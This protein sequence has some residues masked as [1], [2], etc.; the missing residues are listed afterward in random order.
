MSDS[1]DQTRIEM[2]QNAVERLEKRVHNLEVRWEEEIWAGLNGEI[3]QLKGKLEALDEI[4]S[5]NK[6]GSE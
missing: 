4:V 3:A 6:P 2:L 5:R 1:L